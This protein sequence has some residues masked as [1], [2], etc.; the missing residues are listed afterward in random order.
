MAS[1]LLAVFAISALLIGESPL[2][3]GT[4]AIG[5]WLA[6]RRKESVGSP[7]SGW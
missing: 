5:A 3:V 6:S 4:L 1:Y 7:T 2:L